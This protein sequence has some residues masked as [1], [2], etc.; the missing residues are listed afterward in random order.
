MANMIARLWPMPEFPR[1]NRRKTDRRAASAM[2]EVTTMNG[3]NTSSGVLG[4]VSSNGCSF[5]SDGHALRAGQ[6]VTIALD[7]GKPVHAIVR[8]VREETA[9]MEFLRPLSRDQEGWFSL[10]E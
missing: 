7:C 5:L 3:N 1:P 6:F 4:D 8:W 2:A 9:G 10:F